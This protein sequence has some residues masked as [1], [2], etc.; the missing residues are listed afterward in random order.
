MNAVAPA[1]SELLSKECELCA[2]SN[3]VAL[4]EKDGYRY[5]RCVHC[6]LVRAE[7]DHFDPAEL[8]DGLFESAWLEREIARTL[9]PRKQAIYR[10]QLRAAAKRGAF[11]R[12]TTVHVLDVG[13]GVG[14]FLRAARELD[15]APTGLEV[16]DVAARYAREHLGLDVRTGALDRDTHWNA[17]F[18]LV[19]ANA[20]LE[21]LPR[22]LE[23]LSV[24]REALAPGGV[25][26]GLTLNLDS[27][28]Y[29]RA[30]AAWRY[31][32]MGGHVSFFNPQNLH[33]L[34]EKAGFKEVRIR[35]QGFRDESRRMGR[36][37]EAWEG[38]RAARVN[39]GHRLY[40]EAR[41]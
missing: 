6:D 38:R 16:S 27:W 35:T 22:P 29:E 7:M 18:E 28:T 13:C 8:Y 1:T 30:G 21:H 20:L 11:P 2:Q 40:F 33:A 17:R 37:R 10:H 5:A 41:R 25:I 12:G 32:G 39:K 4:L 26:F 34:L 24:L 19:R 15:F 3:L 23:A 9:E 36:W 14:G 31:L